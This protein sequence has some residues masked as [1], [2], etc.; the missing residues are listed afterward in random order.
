MECDPRS[1]ATS[2][3][4][5]LCHEN[6]C[7]MLSFGPAAAKVPCAGLQGDV[8]F[9]PLSEFQQL[10]ACDKEARR[11]AFCSGHAHPIASGSA[12]ILH[13]TRIGHGTR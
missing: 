8:P 9:V 6:S 1:N 5:L 13:C 12:R 3:G 7:H 2:M 11:A 10:E 4:R